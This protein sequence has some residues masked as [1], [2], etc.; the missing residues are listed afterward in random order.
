MSRFLPRHEDLTNV[1]LQ[2]KLEPVGGKLTVLMTIAADVRVSSGRKRFMSEQRIDLQN[3]LDG[4]AAE[5]ERTLG[6]M[7]EQAP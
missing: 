5:T 3:F 7:P 2:A 6:D 1:S 4:C